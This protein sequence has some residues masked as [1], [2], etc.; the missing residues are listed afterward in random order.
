LTSVLPISEPFNEL[1]KRVF[2][3]NPLTRI[4]LHEFRQQVVALKRFLLTPEELVHAPICARIAYAE[5]K[6]GQV[7]SS[8][9]SSGSAIEEEVEPPSS[10]DPSSS[11]SCSG[12]AARLVT[13]PSRPVIPVGIS[14]ENDDIPELPNFSEVVGSPVM[15]TTPRM[16]PKPRFQ[17]QPFQNNHDLPLC[18]GDAWGGLA[19]EK[20]VIPKRRKRVQLA[21]KSRATMSESDSM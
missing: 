20:L 21:Q 4:H 14:P 9:L 1:L 18:T 6:R 2:D 13:P 8:L 10:S 5:A 16:Q 7:S 12:D 19:F 11:G 17:F 3:V 15:P